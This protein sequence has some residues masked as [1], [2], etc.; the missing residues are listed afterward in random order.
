MIGQPEA[1]G[2]PLERYREY[3]R[4]LARLQMDPRLRQKLDPSDVAQETLLQ[5]HAK[6]DQFRGQCEAELAAWLRRILANTLAMALRRYSRQRRD[7]A[8]ERSLEQAVEASSVRLEAWLT[9]DD[10]GPSQQAER[11]EQLLRLAAALE[12]LPAEQRE[13]LELRHLQGRPVAEIGQLMGRSEA[14]VAGLLRR[15]LMTLRERVSD[16]LGDSP[17]EQSRESRQS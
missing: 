4:L 15:G 5:A 3:L 12:Q 11:N 9:L 7:A 2:P 17:D 16:P 10:P 6:K 1:N 14:S 13:A 8:L